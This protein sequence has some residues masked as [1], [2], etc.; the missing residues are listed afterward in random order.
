MPPEPEI[1]Q[2][3]SEVDKLRL[4]NEKVRKAL[5]ARHGELAKMYM[6]LHNRLDILESN[7]CKG[8]YSRED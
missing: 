6:D 1:E 3:K 4:S 5:F 2:L 7:I 8:R